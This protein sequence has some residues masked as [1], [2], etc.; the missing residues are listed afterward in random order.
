MDVT[1]QTFLASID[2]QAQEDIDALTSEV[3]DDHRIRTEHVRADAERRAE[4]SRQAELSAIAQEQR[5][6]SDTRGAEDRR[7]LLAYREAC[8]RE[9][10]EEVVSRVQAF[11]ASA[12]YP[13]HL[14]VLAA[15][16]I[17]AL[18]GNEGCVRVYIRR[19]DMPLADGLR[20]GLLPAS[21]TTEEGDFALGGVIVEL[22]ERG[23][24]AD[25]T[26]E[27]ALREAQDSFGEIFGMEI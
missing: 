12:E 23:L 25:L 16:G 18:G 21:V 14:A 4:A 2:A 13:A 9:V 11:T 10:T 22:P 17:R 1:L 5:V 7:S 15:R 3:A 6:I 27:T 19:E 26:F 20:A 8:S 24:R